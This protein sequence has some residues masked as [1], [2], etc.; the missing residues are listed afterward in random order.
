MDLLYVFIPSVVAGLVQSTTGFGSGIVM[1]LFFPL[2]M[3]LLPAAGLSCLISLFCNS[4]LVVKYRKHIQV[5]MTIFPLLLHFGVCFLALRIS[6]VLPIASL[7]AYFGLFLVILAAYFIFFSNR[8]RIQGG[9]VSAVICSVLAGL[10]NGF[11]GISGP[12]MVVYYLALAGNDKKKYI[13]TIQFF[14]F[15]TSLYAS[16]LRILEGIVTWDLAGMLAAGSIGILLGN[17]IGS[18]ILEKLNV[19]VM[20]KLIYIFLALSGVVTFLSN[21]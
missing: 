21:L 11:F 8:V 4:H 12:P 10:G 15:V 7:K 2:F 18:R 16:V 3:D 5:K 1:M 20:K 9:I 19:E 17:I 6:T 13:G 14:F